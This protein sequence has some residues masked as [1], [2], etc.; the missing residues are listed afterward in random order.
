MCLGICEPF[1]DST[2]N[3]ISAD[4]WGMHTAN[5]DGGS[6]DRGGC[7]SLDFHERISVASLD[8][9]LQIADEKGFGGS[10]YHQEQHDLH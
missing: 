1:L 4:T 10:T 3:L 2:E 7:K 8:Q 5:A 9:W 6:A